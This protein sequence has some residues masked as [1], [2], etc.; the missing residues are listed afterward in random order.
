[1]P[2][3]LNIFG[4]FADLLQISDSKTPEI[5]ETVKTFYINNSITLNILIFSLVPLFY[6]LK[7]NQVITKNYCKRLHYTLLFKIYSPFTLFQL[8]KNLHIL[9]HIMIKHKKIIQEAFN[10]DISL[11]PEITK[12]ENEINSLNHQIFNEENKIKQ[13]EFKELYNDLIVE[14]EKLKLEKIQIF[15]ESHNDT[16]LEMIKDILL[17]YKTIVNLIAPD[18]SINIKRFDKSNNN[19]LE[20]YIRIPSKYE[21]LRT[22]DDM[23]YARKNQETFKIKHESLENLKNYSDFSVNTAYN[24][25]CNF[26]QNERFWICNNLK[27]AEEEK[28]YYSSSKNY[29]KYYDSL[30][31]FLISDK[32]NNEHSSTLKD[33][34]IGLLIFDSKITHAFHHKYIK[35][36]GGYLTHKLYTFLDNQNIYLGSNNIQK[37][38]FKR[39]NNNKFKKKKN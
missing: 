29:S 2:T 12:L 33:S 11:V 34:A 10:A 5:F 15:E 20:T 35:E 38:S 3:L 7:Q 19:N 31:I 18:V 24:Y 32:I 4:S 23:N 21:I 9:E 1:M 36:L 14:V 37:S 30:A 8:I 17:L 22:E 39:N 16:I 6:V 27:K 28:I 13:E 26:Q 25:V